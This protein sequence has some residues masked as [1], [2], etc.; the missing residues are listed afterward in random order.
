MSF[1]LIAIRPLEGCNEKFL[2][3]LLPD[4]VYQFYNDYEF[5]DGVGQTI[6]DYPKSQPVKIVKEK[7]QDVPKNLYGN[8]INVSAIVGK[9]GSGKSALIELLVATIVKISLLINEN[10]IIPEELYDYGENDFDR[11]KFQKNI[12]KFRESIKFD[13][14]NLKV[15]IYFQH[16]SNSYTFR[17]DKVIVDE[18]G[19]E[20]KKIKCIQLDN[21]SIIIK[22]QV[23][24]NVVYF[25]LNDLKDANPNNQKIAHQLYYFLSHL[26][27]TMV[28]NYSHYGFNS[29]E[30]GEWIKGVFHKNDGYQLPV[31]INPYRDKG[32]ININGEIN[33]A[34]SRFLVNVLQDKGLRTIQKNK[35][36]S[37]IT[38]K[39]DNSKFKW[40]ETKNGDLRILNTEED[41]KNILN[42]IFEKFLDNEKLDENNFQNSFFNHAVDYLLI[43][44]YKITNYPIYRDYKKCFKEIIIEQ[45]GYKIYQFRFLINDLLKDYLEHLFINSSHVTDKFNQALFFV[46]YC[47][48]DNKDIAANSV[49]K[50]IEIDTLNEWI[51]NAYIKHF[52]IKKDKNGF[53]EDKIIINEIYEELII[54]GRYPIKYSLPSFFKVEYYFEEK[55]S[56]NNFSSFS[57][58]EKQ[59]I[60]SIHSVI[61][62][63][64]N[65]TSIKD[66]NLIG[67]DNEIKKLITYKNINIIFDEIELYAHPD[68]QRSFIKE[69]LDAIKVIDNIKNHFIN[70]IFITHSPFIL[71]DIPKQNILYLKSEEVEING[72]KSQFS[73]PQTFKDKKSFGANITDLLADSFFVEN[74]LIGDF[75]KRKINKTLNWLRIK[76]NEFNQNNDLKI[77]EKIEYSKYELT[78]E[79]NKKIISLIDEPL[80]KY[81]LNEMYLKYVNDKDYINKEIERLQSLLNP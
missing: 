76:I 39:L 77:D 36:I 69:L 25:S 16:E 54:K 14:N 52:K 26:F 35:T 27:Y 31:V 40:D 80:V 42:I 61:Y 5:V 64:R 45:N 28:I 9:N 29:N 47:Y 66:D 60:F 20:G 65:L 73:I 2:K 21:N 1:K 13:L 48:F 72:K 71:S 22:E 74:G 30:I 32:N 63:L 23:D 51:K 70:I 19:G 38:I 50:I 18:I 55:I 17:S 34:K 57:S 44:L 15:E 11:E 68:F 43:K 41:K 8:N 12:I 56:N 3:N 81:Q 49:E 10:F 53:K 37:H 59:K 58:G 78:N 33:L 7:K 46:Q 4:Q 6:T 79:Y 67:L 62:H 75:A 24:N